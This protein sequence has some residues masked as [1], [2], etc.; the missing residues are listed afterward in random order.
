MSIIDKTDAIRRLE[1]LLSEGDGTYEFEIEINTDDQKA[2]KM[3]LDSLK[4]E[5]AYGLAK[6]DIQT[7]IDAMRENAKKHEKEIRKNGEM[8]AVGLEMSREILN[9]YLKE[10]VK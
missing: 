5:E 9:K 4:R 6:I 1:K 2:I 7:N 8:I 3:A 10:D